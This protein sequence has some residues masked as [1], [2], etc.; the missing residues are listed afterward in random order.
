MNTALY[1]TKLGFSVEIPGQGQKNSVF[2]E[3][4][5]PPAKEASVESVSEL[6]LNSRVEKNSHVYMISRNIST[7][8]SNVPSETV[9]PNLDPSKFKLRMDA[10]T[11]S[12]GD[13]DL[14]TYVIFYSDTA[15]LQTKGIKLSSALTS[16]LL[17]VP[18]DTTRVAV[19]LRI[20]GLGKFEV[21]KLSFEYV[22]LVA[23]LSAKKTTT[24]INKN[25][26][27]PVKNVG[28]PKKSMGADRAK[29]H[30]EK[31]VPTKVVKSS[32]VQP[33]K[34]KPNIEGLGPILGKVVEANDPFMT[35]AVLR[36]VAYNT[37]YRTSINDVLKYLMLNKNEY[38]VLKILDFLGESVGPRRHQIAMDA[39][40]RLLKMDEVVK[41]FENLWSSHGKGVIGVGFYVRALAWTGQTGKLK[42]Q[43]DSLL[44]EASPSNDA[45]E[46]LLGIG[47][48]LSDK[49]LEVMTNVICYQSKRHPNYKQILYLYDL[50]IERGLLDV[51]QRLSPII[52]K[53]DKTAD[54][55]SSVNRLLL[56]SNIAFRSGNFTHQERFLNAAIETTGLLPVRR[57][58]NTKPI[59]AGNI[60]V[61]KDENYHSKLEKDGPKVTVIMTTWCSG[62]TLKY[63]AQ[64]ILD[65]TYRNLELIIID[66]ASSDSTPNIIASLAKTDPRV[67]SIYLKKNGGTYVAKNHGLK[68]AEG[69]Y[70]LCQDS[71]DW[72]HPEKVQKLVTALRENPNLAGVVN[73]LVRLSTESGIQRKPGGFL[74]R[75]ASSLIYNAEKVSKSIGYYDSVRAGG[76]GEFQFRLERMYGQ[77]NV[78]F[79][80]DLLSIVAW[81]G[82]SLSGGGSVYEISNI[83]VFSEARLEYRQ[84]F[85]ERHE[86]DFFRYGTKSLYRP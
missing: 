76:D 44:S 43:I 36:A 59:G 18:K 56:S 15:R 38:A 55:Q 73:G 65:Q 52:A 27:I 74:R 14:K 77:D 78:V 11:K 1:K 61:K 16:C 66:D 17:D 39:L 69:K 85:Q 47:E 72:A 48:I 63:A 58:D 31:P 8:F 35:Q 70:V 7:R 5:L 19:A 20:S 79:L 26:S 68:I 54:V 64:S 3:L 50:L 28:S 53:L 46:A 84:R 49:N 34:R 41:Y 29:P 10:N 71:D 81:G 23:R 62:D 6:V 82:K 13:V 22:R 75:D 45:I 42:K 40:T 60:E 37:D 51:A 25:S 33:Q 32:K 2:E 30:V 12:I 80:R 86:M 83:G 24:S 4:R 9:L 21:S 57:I 67:K